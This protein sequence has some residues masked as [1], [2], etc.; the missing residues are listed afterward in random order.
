V[1][2]DWFGEVRATRNEN[3]WIG[4]NDVRPVVA[5]GMD[6][7]ARANDEE[8]QGEILPFAGTL[9]RDNFHSTPR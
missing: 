5:K 2:P 8:E 4:W 9:S 7:R 3:V 1:G 6:S